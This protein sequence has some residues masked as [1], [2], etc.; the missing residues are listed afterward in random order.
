MVVSPHACSGDEKVYWNQVCL[1]E[2]SA[3]GSWRR[4]GV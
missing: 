3:A 4:G 1:L 2:A